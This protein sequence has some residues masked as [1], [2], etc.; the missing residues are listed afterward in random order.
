MRAQQ[1]QTPGL[2]SSGKQREYRRQAA[3]AWAFI[4]V[5]AAVVIAAVFLLLLQPVRVQGASMEPTLQQGEVLLIDRL[6]MYVK[7][8]NRGDMVI[9]PH[10]ATGEELIKRVI[11]FAGETVELEAGVVYVD[12]RALDEGSYVPAAQGEMA[13]LVVPEGSVFVLGDNRAESFDSRDPALGCIPLSSLDGIVRLRVAPL[14]RI[15]LFV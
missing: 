14:D 8:P 5:Q 1:E 12:G 9:F 2:R 7:T 15:N 11:A 6:A 3:W 4:L 10:P 13:A